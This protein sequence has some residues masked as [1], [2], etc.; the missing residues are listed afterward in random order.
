MIVVDDASTDDTAATVTAVDAVEYVRLDARRG[1][2]EA[3]NAGVA[4]A[5]GE[6]VLFLDDDD[7]LEPGA[8]EVC[9]SLIG[10]HPAIHL[11][12]HNCYYGDGRPAIP[13]NTPP[14]PYTYDDWLD[15]R[16]DV[17]LKPMVRRRV[18]ERYGF[19]DTG[20]GGEGLMWARIIRDHGALVDGR[21]IIRYDTKSVSR[22]TSAVGLLTHA[23]AN[24]RIADAWLEAFGADVRVRNPRRW[25]R[26]VLAAATYHVVCG[27]RSHARQLVRSIPPHVL[28][29]SER[30]AFWT[31]SYAP[32]PLARV[33]FIAH[34][35][36]LIAT[37][38]MGRGWWRPLM[39]A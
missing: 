31:A 22:L 23:E 10:A 2:C 5:S 20:A 12:F 28:S 27:R 33:L 1:P 15:G 25:A 24:S 34:R 36:E 18:F 6:F 29:L 39:S 35:R 7:Y 32:V 9:R 26:R 17:E 16:F 30:A 14:T 4:H 38:R 37:I 19:P 13:V 3:R 21:P 8:L 11:F